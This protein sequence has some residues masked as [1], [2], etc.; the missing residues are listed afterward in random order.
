MKRFQFLRQL[1]YDVQRGCPELHSYHY[2]LSS[3]FICSLVIQ[4]MR[5]L[6]LIYILLAMMVRKQ[7]PSML[8]PLV[9]YEQ[10]RLTHANSPAHGM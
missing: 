6:L 4:S 1:R 5:V 10:H 9:N 2:E 8:M 7:S 3:Q